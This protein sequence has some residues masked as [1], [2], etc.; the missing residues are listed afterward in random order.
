MLYDQTQAVDRARSQRSLMSDNHPL[1]SWTSDTQPV[2][3]W[4]IL[5]LLLASYPRSIRSFR[6]NLLKSREESVPNVLSSSHIQEPRTPLCASL[7]TNLRVEPRALLSTQR[8]DRSHHGRTAPGRR[9]VQ[10]TQEEEEGAYTRREGG[11]I[12]TREGI[13]LIHHL[14]ISPLYTTWVYPS[15]YTRGYSSLSGTR[16]YSSLSDTRGLVYY[17]HPWASVLP[18]PVGYC[19]YDTRGLLPLRHPWVNV[20]PTPVG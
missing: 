19:L 16:G 6:F 20:L 7:W 18:T 14:G 13:L 2:S 4:A 17:R 15:L 1:I 10:Y 11:S 12:Y 5:P 3:D 8:Y 9:R